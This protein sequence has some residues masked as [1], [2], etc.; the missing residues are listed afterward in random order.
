MTTILQDLRYAVRMLLKNPGFTV[1]AVLTLALGIGANTAIFSVVNGLLLHPY[2][3]A[4]PERLLAVRVRYEKLNLKNIAISA[5]DFTFVRDNKQT[6]AA[7]AIQT[8]SDFNYATGSWP[9]RPRGARVSSQWFD[10]FETK[11]LLGRVFTPEEDQPNADRQVVLA[12]HTWKSIFGGET[13]VVDR[14]VQL[15]Q[16]PYKII[17]VMPETFQ[18]PSQT[19]LWAPLALPPNAFVIDNIFNESYFAVARLQ[20]NAKFSHA[21]TFLNMTSQQIIDDPRTQ[22]YPKASGWSPFAVPLTEFVY[23]DARTPVLILLGA[24][25]FVLLIACSNV[26]G[27]LLA[28]A[29]ARAKEFSIRTALG[30]SPWR[31]ARQMLTESVVLA[32]IGMAFGLLLAW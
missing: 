13:G 6:F 31:L 8:E 26:A 18:W 25:S 14:S 2:G 9:L 21:A 30:G 17:G 10:V 27:L 5:P 28:R 32:G 16:Q 19:D 7:S 11:P 23:G 15:N 24:V 12:Y 20:A 22:G 3:I 29:S 1:V 4:H